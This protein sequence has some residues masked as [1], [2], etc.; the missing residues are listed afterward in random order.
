MGLSVVA[1]AALVVVSVCISVEIFSSAMLPSLDDMNDSFTELKKRRV[2]S[3]QSSLNITDVDVAVNGSNFDY[4]VTVENMGSI[5]LQPSQFVVLVNGTSC[6][7]FCSVLYLHPRGVE[8]ITLYDVSFG[9]PVRFKIV[10]NTGVE[11]YYEF[12]G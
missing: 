4:M 9:S 10:A 6:V 1:V 12:V 11:A 7:F 8:M 2:D 3:V 5:S